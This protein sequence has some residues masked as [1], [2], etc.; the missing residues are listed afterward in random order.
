MRHTELCIVSIMLLRNTTMIQLPHLS[1]VFI[2]SGE[3]EAE[4]KW[5]LSSLHNV[6]VLSEAVQIE[7]LIYILSIQGIYWR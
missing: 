6:G 3:I 5:W 2:M 4:I 7:H 1:I